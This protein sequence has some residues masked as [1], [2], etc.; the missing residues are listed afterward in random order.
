M[1]FRID[2]KV[3][4]AR[5]RFLERVWKEAFDENK[6]ELGRRL[7]YKD[8]SFVGQMLRNE[9]PVT[10]ATWNKLTRLSEVRERGLAG[11]VIALPPS[12]QIGDE[13]KPGVAR[14]VSER[15]HIVTPR[16]LIWGDFVLSEIQ[17]EF[18]MAVAGDA[19]APH[20]LPGERGIWLACDY[21]RPGKAVLLVDEAE[22]FYLRIYEPRAGQSWAGV[23][24][25]PGQ[26]GHRELTPER[27][28]VRIVARILWRS[29]D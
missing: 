9:K 25:R 6:A 17:G 29:E 5:I 24:G 2:P 20:Y 18:V 16:T 10:E 23:S 15:S 4:E 1:A 7:G 22:E 12:P 14:A 19:L 21:G 3:Q 28:G 13:D 11:N 8:G 27:D 26:P